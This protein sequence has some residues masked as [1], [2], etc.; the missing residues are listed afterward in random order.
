MSL[1]D[2]EEITLLTA[3]LPADFNKSLC[4]LSCSFVSLMARL[5][6]SPLYLS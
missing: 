6:Y 1:S 5:I 2:D 4:D 3:P